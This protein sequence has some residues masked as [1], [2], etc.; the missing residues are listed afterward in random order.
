MKTTVTPNVKT[1]KTSNRKKIQS[2]LGSSAFINIP[3]DIMM[4]S[5]TP[6]NTNSQ[7]TKKEEASLSHTP[8]Y[9]PSNEHKNESD[10]VTP[11][12]DLTKTTSSKSKMSNNDKVT[13][14]GSDK[15]AKEKEKKLK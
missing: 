3:K 15:K 2:T 13:K 8:T 14:S 10:K 1:Q 9:K 4:K 11:I 7:P 12:P 5:S 6:I